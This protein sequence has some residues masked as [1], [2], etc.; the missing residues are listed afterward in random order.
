MS[1]QCLVDVE[2]ER[3]ALQDPVARVLVGGEVGGEDESNAAGVGA[4]LRHVDGRLED[5]RQLQLGR[6]H[7]NNLQHGQLLHEHLGVLALEHA[8]LRV[9]RGALEVQSLDVTPE[10]ELLRH[11]LRVLVARHRR[12]QRGLVE[13][14]TLLAARRLPQPQPP[15]PPPHVSIRQGRS[16][17][18]RSYIL[19]YTTATLRLLAGAFFSYLNLNEAGAPARARRC[20]SRAIYMWAYLHERGD[21][22]LGDVQPAEPNN[23]R[24]PDLGP[25]AVLAVAALEPEH[26]APEHLLRGGVQPCPHRRQLPVEQRGRQQVQVRAHANLPGERALEGTVGGRNG[27]RNSQRSRARF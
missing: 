18:C 8:R 19:R 16:R 22:G 9:P 27:Q 26:P 10:L 6:L 4:R 1:S 17:T 13:G 24:L 12:V 21:V 14:P 7:G 2:A 5:V 15:P 11:A 23:A 3:G 20:R 25:V